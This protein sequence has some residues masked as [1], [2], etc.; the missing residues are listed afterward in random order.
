M[1]LSEKHDENNLLGKIL[2]Y[3]YKVLDTKKRIVELK[4]V[5]LDREQKLLDLQIFTSKLPELYVTHENILADMALGVDRQK[6]LGEI[7]AQISMEVEKQKEYE[8]TISEATATENP[9]LAGLHRKLAETEK[10]LSELK[11]MKSPMLAEFL[12]A[13]AEQLGIIYVQSIETAAAKIS[14]IRALGGLINN[15]GG[16]ISNNYS[17]YHLEAPLFNLK[18]CID[19][20]HPT[21]PGRLSAVVKSGPWQDLE[22]IT[23][24]EIER[25][26]V[27]GVEL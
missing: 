27:M 19:N 17:G 10:E 16:K 8:E 12:T 20:R 18:A 25:F 5:I 2:S 14:Q 15:H 3:Q 21:D 9:I 23:K 13:E 22:S 1:K 11:S 4:R 7:V 24:A 26:M 6:D